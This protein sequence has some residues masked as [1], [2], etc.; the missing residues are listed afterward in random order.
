[1]ECWEGKPFPLRRVVLLLPPLDPTFPRLLTGGEAQEE[2]P[3]WRE[4]E[5]HFPAVDNMDGFTRFPGMLKKCPWRFVAKGL[6]SVCTHQGCRSAMLPQAP[7][8]KRCLLSDL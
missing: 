4:L 1:M 5:R 8:Y 2:A 7:R 6:L 3:A